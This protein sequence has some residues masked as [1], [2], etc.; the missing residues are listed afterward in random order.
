MMPSLRRCYPRQLKYISLLRN[1]MKN[2]DL[3]ANILNVL[4]DNEDITQKFSESELKVMEKEVLEFLNVKDSL[5]QRMEAMNSL[6]IEHLKPEDLTEEET[7][8]LLDALLKL[9]SDMDDVDEVYSKL[10]KG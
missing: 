5:T 10:I 7:E 6:D 8:E 4:A 2:K 9:K 3:K 1:K